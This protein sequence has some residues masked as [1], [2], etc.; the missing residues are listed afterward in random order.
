MNLREKA[1]RMLS[2]PGHA[3]SVERAHSI[4]QSGLVFLIFQIVWLSSP[5]S[6]LDILKQK[7]RAQIGPQRSSHFPQLYRRILLLIC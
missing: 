1:G 5:L 2:V 7:L 6:P 4:G 3:L